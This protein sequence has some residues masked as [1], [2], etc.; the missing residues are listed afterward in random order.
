[1]LYTHD[2][3][4]SDMSLLVAGCITFFMALMKNW[5]ERQKSE[6]LQNP[7][8]PNVDAQKV[9]KCFFLCIKVREQEACGM[10]GNPIERIK[11]NHNPTF[12]KGRAKVKDQANHGQTFADRIW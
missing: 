10:L 2:E 4:L 11:A 3:E 9:R 6:K 5:Y 1:M 8:P 7:V 12:R